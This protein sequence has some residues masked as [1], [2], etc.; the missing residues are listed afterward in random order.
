MRPLLNSKQ[1]A[2]LEACVVGLVA[3]IASVLLKEAVGWLG[4]WRVA[5]AKQYPVW[6]VL[7]CMGLVGGCLAGWL[8]QRVAPETAGS[9]IPQVKAVLAQLPVSL[10]WRTAI[11]KLIGTTL[12]LGSG[13]ALG[14]QGPTVQIGA[15]LAAQLSEWVP[16]SPEYRRQLI[17]AG[18]AAGLA[19]GFNAPLAGVLF[20]IEELLH[21]LSGITLT[22]TILASLIG[23]VVSRLL[24]GQGFRL[25]I[26]LGQQSQV[27]VQELPFFLML[28]VVVG[29]LA[30]LFMVS[31]LASLRYS[32]RYLRIGVM[33]RIALVGL[34]SGAIVSQLPAEFRDS[35]GLQG[36]LTLGIAD[37][38]FAL[39]VFVIRFYLSVLACSAE[40]P[41]GL[42]VPSLI[43]GAA[44]G[45]E[46][47]ILEQFWQGVGQPATYALAGMGAFFGAVTKTPVTAIVIVFEITRD[48][49]LVL[50][51]MMA[52]VIAYLVAERCL[53]GSLYTKLLE[54][55]GMKLPEAQSSALW[56]QLRAGDVMQTKVE[57]LASDLTLAEAIQ[58]FARSH[59]RGFP[60]LTGGELVGII[61]QTDLAKASELN[62]P[63]ET[64]IAQIMT[65]SP[66]TVHPSDSLAHVLYLLSHYKLSRLPVL[67]QKKLVGIITRSDILRAEAEKLRS[68]A[69]K[70]NPDPSYVVYQTQAPAIGKGRVLLPLSNPHTAP[71]LIKLAITIAQRCE[72]ELE[73]L[74]VILIPWGQS[75]S[76]A[77]VEIAPSKALLDLTQTYSQTIPIH[78]QIRVAHGVVPAILETIATRHINIL[79]M[80]WR[81]QQLLSQFIL[82]DVA[83][84]VIRQATCD[85]VLVKFP[86]NYDHSRSICRW[87]IPVSDRLNPTYAPKLLNALISAEFSQHQ[88]IVIT[89][90]HLLEK[91]PNTLIRKAS[92]HMRTLLKQLDRLHENTQ[93]ISELNTISICNAS[94]AEGV[95]DIAE[96]GKYDAILLSAKAEE[97]LQP[98]IKEIARHTPC[99]LFLVRT[100]GQAQIN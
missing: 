29:L 27:L 52:V 3:A 21:D 24:G 98:E 83:D 31:V 40:S 50:P 86:E 1:T 43:L 42:F 39:F 76:E 82:G 69:L 81:G 14:R 73:C 78:H 34:L 90:A 68:P 66:I 51:L 23:G 15:G 57:T 20:V 11:F 60:V 25:D 79:L 63:L 8:V 16:T 56:M 49:N 32:Y 13:F 19:A 77:P 65:R 18:A 59:H 71:H 58:A 94:V 55:K 6:V 22:T 30:A 45:A 10:N 38:Q 35:A 47:G 9:G 33:G 28:G 44:V 99:P 67:E 92:N 70:Q 96:K 95:L 12:T 61:T 85:V 88:P 80:G 93:A 5:L 41:G 17:A 75:T 72:Y 64:P 62:L 46:I 36:L 84:T 48:F 54:L 53:P 74:Q 97:M 87:L 91:P 4:G 37:W 26:E 7:P 89:L 2:A 100:H